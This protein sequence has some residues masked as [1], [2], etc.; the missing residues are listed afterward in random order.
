MRKYEINKGVGRSLEFKGFRSTYIF[1][2]AG[3]FFLAFFLYVVLSL[4]LSG[5][6]AVVVSVVFAALG[7][8]FVSWLNARYKEK[9]LSQMFSR[10]RATGRVHY[11][12]RMYKIVYDV[13]S[14]VE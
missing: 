10:K 9:G 14:Q 12:K 5:T 13:Q 11:G 2:L 1:I 3:L 4:I 7:F 6:A 8:F